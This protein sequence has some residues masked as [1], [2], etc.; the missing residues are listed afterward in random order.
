VFEADCRLRAS[1]GDSFGSFRFA[2]NPS[3]TSR[4]MAFQSATASP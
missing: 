2:F 3:S 1:K 4:R